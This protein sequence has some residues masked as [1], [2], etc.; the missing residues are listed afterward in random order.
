VESAFVAAGFVPEGKFDPIPESELIVDNAKIVLD[1]VLG[2]AEGVGD[3]AVL[4]ALG[5]EFDDSLF[6]FAGES[7]PVAFVS[8][9]SCLR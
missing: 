9:H 2:S 5:N 4:K 3:F 8:E 6:S 7:L 1:D